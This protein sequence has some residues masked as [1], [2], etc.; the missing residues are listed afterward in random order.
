MEPKTPESA[1]PK[2]ITQ[3]RGNITEVPGY[4]PEITLKAEEVGAN[5]WLQ[6]VEDTQRDLRERYTSVIRYRRNNRLEATP[7]IIGEPAKNDKDIPHV[8][9][10][11]QPFLK[12][13]LTKKVSDTHSHP[14]DPSI[15]EIARLKT[16]F[17]ST[18]DI[19]PLT[20]PNWK[21]CRI[22]VDRGG[23]HLL[24]KTGESIHRH[25][26]PPPDLIEKVL[27]EVGD[28]HGTVSEIQKRINGLLYEY[29]ISY[30]YRESL[31]PDEDGT[32]T[33]KKP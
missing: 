26:P 28:R 5:L 30:F 17:P 12:G 10:E 23:A 19:I 16:T 27:K 24:I 7:V 29:G 31:T 22:I 9:P 1:I 15:P 2:P 8:L 25:E 4:N 11:P 21:G 14:L 32:V 33:F 18:A 13:L 6:L 20:I 3:I